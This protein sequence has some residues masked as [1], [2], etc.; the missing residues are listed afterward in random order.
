MI[1][2]QQYI[3][4]E[5]KENIWQKYGSCISYFSVIQ[6]NIIFSF[7]RFP[8]TFF[9]F[10]LNFFKMVNNNKILWEKIEKINFE[11]VEELKIKLEEKYGNIPSY[12]FIDH[13]FQFYFIILNNILI[14]NKNSETLFKSAIEEIDPIEDRI[15]HVCYDKYNKKLLFF[16]N[17]SGKHKILLYNL[18]NRNFS[19]SGS[20]NISLGDNKKSLG[21]ILSIIK[22]DIFFIFRPSYRIIL[23]KD[24]KKIIIKEIDDNKLKTKKH[25]FV[26]GNFLEK[27]KVICLVSIFHNTGYSYVYFIAPSLNFFSKEKINNK[28]IGIPFSISYITESSYL[29]TLSCVPW[30]FKICQFKILPQK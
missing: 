5:G 26:S 11:K 10:D 30:Y 3:E 23:I 27:Y 19:L 21:S 6:N 12:F 29:Y 7:A 13:F 8:L 18:H 22:K 17:S 9:K 20:L 28:K 15:I 14:F 16:L 4:V 24:L 25:L 1:I 2:L